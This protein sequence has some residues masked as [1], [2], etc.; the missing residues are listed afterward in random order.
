MHAIM[1]VT[2]LLPSILP[3]T[4]VSIPFSFLKSLTCSFDVV[5]T[6]SFDVIIT[7]IVIIQY[8]KY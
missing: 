2:L 5:H 1:R 4:V 3:N 6:V 8:V 7:V